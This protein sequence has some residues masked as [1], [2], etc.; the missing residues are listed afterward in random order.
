[1]GMGTGGSSQNGNGGAV[2]I[3]DASTEAGP[4]GT[5][6]SGTSTD[7]GTDGS[8]HPPDAGGDASD[9]GADAGPEGGIDADTDSG[10]SDAGPG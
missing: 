5:G 8:D 1:M 9:A 4:Q 10:A 6:G 3:P 2:F 7:A